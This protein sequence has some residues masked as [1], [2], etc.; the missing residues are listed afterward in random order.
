MNNEDILT[1]IDKF[2]DAINKVPLRLDTEHK[3]LLVASN[4]NI[5]IFKIPIDDIFIKYRN[6][7]IFAVTA[8]AISSDEFYRPK[9]VSEKLYGTT[10][11]WLALLRLN[12]M[13]DIT[14]FCLPEILIYS[15]AVVQNLLELILQKE[16]IV[17]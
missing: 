8:T 9:L 14:E 4:P 6:R 16:G 1:Y 10:E 12:K 11:L 7:L 3:S 15:P 17:K 13:R 5:H 2:L